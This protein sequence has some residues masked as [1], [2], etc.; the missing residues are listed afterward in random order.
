MGDEHSAGKGAC[1]QHEEAYDNYVVSTRKSRR[2]YIC[3]RSTEQSTDNGTN[4]HH[5][6]CVVDSVKHLYPLQKHDH[7]KRQFVPISRP[8]FGRTPDVI[9]NEVR[10]RALLCGELYASLFANGGKNDLVFKEARRQ[11]VAEV[12]RRC[13]RAR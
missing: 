10:P 3:S 11:F 13:L 8:V 2:R 7:L 4:E 6:Q 9:D 5:S 12:A 1:P